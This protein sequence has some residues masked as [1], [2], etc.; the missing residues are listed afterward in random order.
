[1]IFIVSKLQIFTLTNGPQLAAS[2]VN[3]QVFSEIFVAVMAVL[4][5]S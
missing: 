5:S 3:M 4:K 2:G 1:M